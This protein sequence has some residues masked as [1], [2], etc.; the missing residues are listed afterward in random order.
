[1]N[2]SVKLYLVVFLVSFICLMLEAFL[3]K[4]SG[5]FGLILCIASL[6]FIVGTIIRLIRL[7]AFVD[8]DIM[9]KIDILFF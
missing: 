3:F 7:S 2:K 6:Y 4:F 5:A 1:M 8:D 9:E